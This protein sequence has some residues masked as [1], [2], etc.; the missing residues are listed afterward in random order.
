MRKIFLE[1]GRKETFLYSG[2]KFS[3]ID[4][5]GN[6]ENRNCTD[7]PCDLATKLSRHSVDSATWPLPTP[8]LK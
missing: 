7:E 2:G 6:L 4:L 1:S 3:N 5:H 8:T